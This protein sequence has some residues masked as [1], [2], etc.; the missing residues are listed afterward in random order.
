[1]ILQRDLNQG[2]KIFE[3]DLSETLKMSRTPVREA[4]LRLEQE[5]LVENQNR[6]GFHRSGRLQSESE[7]VDYYDIREVLEVFAAPL[8]V[9][10]ITDAEIAGAGEQCGCKPR[11]YYRIRGQP[12]SCFMRQPVS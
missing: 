9:A 11:T 5:N 3:K 8:M 10:K 1:M 7:I 6:L 12:K 2:D 4:L